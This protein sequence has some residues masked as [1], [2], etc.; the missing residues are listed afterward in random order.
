MMCRLLRLLPSPFVLSSFHISV[1]AI[2]T[3]ITTI[4][5]V[6][7]NATTAPILTTVKSV[8]AANVAVLS[9]LQEPGCSTHQHVC[10]AQSWALL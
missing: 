1:V 8:I 3:I 4:A 10:Y 6:I 9:S 5:I 7:A 2:V